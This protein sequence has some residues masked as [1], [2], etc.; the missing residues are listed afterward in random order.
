MEESSPEDPFALSDTSEELRSARRNS[1]GAA[2]S[3][4]SAK[5]Q[6]VKSHSDA[7]QKN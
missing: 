1:G 6:R 2:S 5:R 7:D 3:G 4:R